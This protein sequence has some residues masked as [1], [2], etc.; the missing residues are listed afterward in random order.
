LELDPNGMAISVMKR[1]NDR[2]TRMI[3]T[4]D[5]NTKVMFHDEKKNLSDVKVG[6]KVTV[7]YVRSEGTLSAKTIIIEN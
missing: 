4:T 1:I 7:V 5:V 6:N 2:D 3:F